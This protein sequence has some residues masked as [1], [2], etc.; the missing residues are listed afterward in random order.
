MLS[1]FSAAPFMLFLILI[2]LSPILA[3]STSSNNNSM[4]PYIDPTHGVKIQYPS[5][6]KLVERG[7]NGYH[8]LNVIA[9]FLLPYQNNY[10]NTNISASHN[11]LRLS[12]ENYSTFEE[13]PGDNSTN[14]NSNM[15]DNQ[16]QN[17][18]NHRIGSIGLSCPGFDLKV[19][20][21]M[22]PWL[23]AQHIRSALIILIWI[24]IKRQ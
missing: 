5:D 3:F 7:D 24:I 20:F 21:A 2:P 8:M 23:G 16:L 4:K 11:S 19:M 9:E 1:V 22:Q 15:T 17:I 6:W 12:V 10:Y 18:G 13:T 14:N